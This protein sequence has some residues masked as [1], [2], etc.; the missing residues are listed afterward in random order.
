MST[1]SPR[2]GILSR[3]TIVWFG[4]AA[5]TERKIASAGPKNRRGS[6][7]VTLL[8]RRS[9][10]SA[11]E[12]KSALGPRRP[13]SAPVTLGQMAELGLVPAMRQGRGHRHPEHTFTA[14]I[15]EPLRGEAAAPSVEGGG[16][17]PDPPPKRKPRACDSLFGLSTV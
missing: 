5:Q 12:E 11:L 7:A 6:L 17:E 3:R 10:Q 9:T 8:R 14:T 1:A 2:L 4:N 15:S 16:E 13:A